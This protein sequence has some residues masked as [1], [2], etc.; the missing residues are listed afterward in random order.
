M[1]R[2][3]YPDRAGR[4]ATAARPAG[5]QTIYGTFGDASVLGWTANH[6]G[7]VACLG[8]SFFVISGGQPGST[9]TPPRSRRRTGQA[10][11][12][13]KT[14]DI[15]A[16]GYWTI[17]NYE[18]L[19]GLAAYRWLAQQVGNTGQEKWAAAEYA[20]LLAATNKVLNAT[21][22]TNHLSYLP[23]SMTE[24]NTANRCANAEDANW[25]APFL[26]GRWAWDGY[27]FG[28]PRSGPGLSLI[29]ATYGYGSYDDS[30]T[31]WANAS[32]AIRRSTTAPPT[33]RATGNGG[34]P[35]GRRLR[36]ARLGHCQRQP[37]AARLAGGAARDGSLIVGR[38]VPALGARGQVTSLAHVPR[39]RPAPGLSIRAQGAAVT[40]SLSGQRPA[41]PV[42]FQLP[43]FVRNIAHAS[44][45]TVDEQTGTVTVPPSRAHRLLGGAQ[46]V[47]R[48][49]GPEAEHVAQDERSALP[50]RQ[51]LE[52]GDERQRDG[53]ARL[54]P[55]LRP[56]RGVRHAVQQAVRVGLQ[57]G[58]LAEPGGIGR[59]GQRPGGG[60]RPAAARPQRVQAAAGRHPVQPGTD[61]R[62][63]LETGQ[64]APGGQQGLLQRVL[65]ILE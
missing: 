8:G 57:P 2:P 32:M 19:M 26:F 28:A 63:A 62:P 49:A 36:G 65:G 9:R 54:V 18:A 11:I 55:G 60:R 59:V 20:S 1:A 53:L 44:A 47:R 45:G 31:T 33:T 52:S 61:R 14:N 43:A 50:G 3:G 15:D 4:A 5:S 30:P 35:G 40:L 34:W 12:M 25:A 6:Q 56:R 23:C 46:R 38:G 48:L 29:D 64:A 21:I 27:L 58:H 42:L 10:G 39:W 13:E 22:A 17:D 16:N 24:P 7:V 37:G 51:D 41:G